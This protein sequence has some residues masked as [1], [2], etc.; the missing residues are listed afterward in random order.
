MRM[1]APSASSHSSAA[2]RPAAATATSTSRRWQFSRH[3]RRGSAVMRGGFISVR[4]S[5]WRPHCSALYPTSGA[6]GARLA[7]AGAGQTCARAARRAAGQPAAAMGRLS[8][9]PAQ[10]R[11]DLRLSSPP[12]TL[13]HCARPVARLSAGGPAADARLPLTSCPLSAARASESAVWA[14]RRPDRASPQ[15][16]SRTQRGVR[17]TVFCWRGSADWM[18]K[19]PASDRDAPSARRAE[20]W[21]RTRTLMP[22]TRARSSN[23]RPTY[24]SGQCGTW[25][26]RWFRTLAAAGEG[27]G[28]RQSRVSR[29]G[30]SATASCTS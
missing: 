13:R 24:R 15:G 7:A 12:E 3:L 1:A 17:A 21:R 18:S 25:V 19:Q 20:R 26:A 27:D 6:E 28:R 22:R 10:C 4:A 2:R 9:E 29:R 23:E 11:Q 5:T 14:R 30:S 16:H 8:S